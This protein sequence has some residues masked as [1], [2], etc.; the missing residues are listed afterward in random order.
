MHGSPVPPNTLSIL[1][2]RCAWSGVLSLLDSGPLFVQA[3]APSCCLYAGGTRA[4]PN[5]P[6]L[7]YLLHLTFV[8]YG[9][10]C[11]SKTRSGHSQ[12]SFWLRPVC[13]FPDMLWC[14]KGVRPIEWVESVSPQ[15]NCSVQIIYPAI[16]P[17]TSRSPKKPQEAS[18]IS[19]K[20]H[21]AIFI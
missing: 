1:R 5:A 7:G 6:S 9:L 15:S 18:N 4:S 19:E 16:H 21:G 17:V 11:V 10:T 8:T 13:P 3:Y 12:G 14:S 2:H 20:I